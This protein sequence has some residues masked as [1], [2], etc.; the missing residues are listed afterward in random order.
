MTDPLQHL[1]FDALIERSLTEPA[2]VDELER[3]HL[4]ETAIL[5]VDFS[6]MVRR[7]PAHGIV[8]ALA[9]ARAVMDAIKPA[10]TAHGGQVVSPLAD[11]LLATLPSPAD[12]LHAALDGQQAL[13]QRHPDSPCTLSTGIGLGFGKCLLVAEAG[14]FG[15]AVSR[16]RVL[17]GDTALPGEILVTEAF[18]AG[19]GAVPNGIGSFRAR[20]DRIHTT[21]FRFHQ[22]RDYRA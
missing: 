4:T 10:V 15:E 7:A 21:G 22:I 19:L 14:I 16:A 1:D 5:V 6:E 8:T 3:R 9:R 12:A 13:R 20:H 11:A 18:L 17:G 2:A